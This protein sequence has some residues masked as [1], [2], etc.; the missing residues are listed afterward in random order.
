MMRCFVAILTLVLMASIGMAAVGGGPEA[1]TLERIVS[2]T[3][4]KNFSVQSTEAQ[5]LAQMKRIRKARSALLPTVNLTGVYTH[6]GVVPEFEIPG[7]ENIKFV[8]PDTLNF[9]LGVKYNL[10]DWGMSRDQIKLERLGLE[11]TRLSGLLLKKGL[12]M[13]VSILYLNILQIEE[14]ERVILDNIAILEKILDVSR[15]Q[16]DGGFVPEHQVL[17][18]R[19]VLE[20]LK[21]QKLQLEQARTEMLMT[22]KNV[23]GQALDSQLTLQKIDWDER[24]GGMNLD[25]LVE[26]AFGQREDL[27]LLSKQ[28]DI[29][30]RT[31]DL[32]GKTRLPLVSA[33][34]NAELRNGIMPDV[35]KLKMN[36]SVG[37]TVVYNLFDGNASKY[38]QEALA[39]QLQDLEISI[40]KTRRDLEAAVRQG[41]EKM[42]RLGKIAELERQ[43][44][45]ISR[46]GLELAEQSFEAGQAGYLDV[47]NARSNVNMAENNVI[48]AK[49][50]RYIQWLTIRNET[51]G[52][53]GLVDMEAK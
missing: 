19:S 22:L 23:S 49:Y 32:I 34:L 44:L 18:T 29:L 2:Q 53:Q 40:K 9:S 1:V 46:R 6:I 39:H 14:G 42:E 11:S 38:E 5:V 41:L 10:F 24:L 47:L 25:S 48:A 16:F 52:L 31:R 3:L 50:Q 20:S 51:S 12:V 17:Q 13:Q 37:L 36:W 26:K 35:E 28:A 7:F 8:N 43:R 30:S 33:G 21:A 27:M 45:D 4:E 15:R